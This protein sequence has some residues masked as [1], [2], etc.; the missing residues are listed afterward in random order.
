LVLPCFLLLCFFFSAF[1]EWEIVG[2]GLDD[3]AQLDA[4]VVTDFSEVVTAIVQTFKTL[5]E[6]SQQ[7]AKGPPLKM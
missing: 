6:Y 5:D 1:Q 7:L 2:I 4:F 3:Y